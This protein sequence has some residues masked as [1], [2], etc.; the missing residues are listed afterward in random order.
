HPAG[1]RWVGRVYVF[2]GALPT[3]VLA[4]SIVPFSQG[5]AGNTVAA[6]LWLTTT[7]TGYRMARRDRET[8]HRRWMTYSFALTLQIVWGRV[9]FVVLPLIPGVNMADPHT[10]GLIFE[11]ASWIGILIN[12]LAAQVWLEWTSRRTATRNVRMGP[13]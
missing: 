11:T 10:L 13:F 5:P 7:I 6:L 12:L 3:A 2:G 1:H 9:M 4:L 8:D